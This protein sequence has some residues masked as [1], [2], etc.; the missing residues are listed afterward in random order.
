M[1]MVQSSSELEG[2]PAETQ[3]IHEGVDGMEERVMRDRMIGLIQHS[4]DGCAR[5]WAEVIADHLLAN[6]L[7]RPSWMY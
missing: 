5:H 6:G 4:V 7:R 1:E 2:H 3:G